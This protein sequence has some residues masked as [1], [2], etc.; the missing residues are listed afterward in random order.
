MIWGLGALLNRTQGRQVE[1]AE[2]KCVHDDRV[3]MDT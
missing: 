1:E 3:A 2:M